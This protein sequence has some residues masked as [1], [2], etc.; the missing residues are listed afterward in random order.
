MTI[1]NKSSSKETKQN[2]KQETTEKITE[3]GRRLFMVKKKLLSVALVA[4]TVCSM[5]V[6]PVRDRQRGSEE[7]P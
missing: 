6:P 5:T 4:V 3:Y 7:S 1:I 2:K